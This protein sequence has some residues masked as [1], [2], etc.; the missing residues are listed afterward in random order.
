MH[1]CHIAALKTQLHAA[2]QPGSKPPA[3]KQESGRAAE[4]GPSAAV[5]GHDEVAGYRQTISELR[6]A[7][8]GKSRGA[9]ADSV[10]SG[11]TPGRRGGQAGRAE[12]DRHL[13]Q[14]RRAAEADKAASLQSLRDLFQR[15]CLQIPLKTTVA[16]CSL[17]Q[18]LTRLRPCK[19]LGT[20][21]WG[22]ALP[23]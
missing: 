15:C 6:A 11:A 14:Q 2:M 20:C 21:S 1:G 5:L 18:M 10:K 3:V 4:A 23:R 22:A 9:A 13:E 19:A 17:P 8:E 16:R 12:L 7:L